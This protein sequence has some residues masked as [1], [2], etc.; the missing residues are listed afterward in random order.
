MQ[1]TRDFRPVA[2]RIEFGEATHA[3]LR[4]V[5]S[6][7]HSKTSVGESSRADAGGKRQ[8]DSAQTDMH[9]RQTCSV[10][11]GTLNVPGRHFRH[12]ANPVR[13]E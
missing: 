9:I 7:L 12:W 6:A 2:P 5:H 8:P 4:A 10:D 1:R 3:A 13:S 11:R